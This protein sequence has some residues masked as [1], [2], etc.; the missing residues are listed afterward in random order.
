MYI[1]QNYL[2]SYLRYLPSIRYYLGVTYTYL[3]YWNRA[4]EKIE[5]AEFFYCRR[6]VYLISFVICGKA[7]DE[8]IHKAWNSRCYL[9]VEPSRYM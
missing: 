3:T 9:G 6:Y 4:D 8:H 1:F 5:S 2:T 7:C